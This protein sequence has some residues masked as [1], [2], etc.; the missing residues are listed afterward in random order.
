[1]EAGDDDVN[2]NGWTVY[3][4]RSPDTSLMLS[5]LA[6]HGAGCIRAPLSTSILPREAI[7]GSG[8]QRV[9]R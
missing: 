5:L 3:S 1:M 9:W 8:W 4:W 6:N 2:A 7:A